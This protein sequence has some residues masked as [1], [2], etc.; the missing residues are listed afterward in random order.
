MPDRNGFVHRLPQSGIVTDSELAEAMQC[1]RETIGDWLLKYEIDHGWTG[2][3][4]IIDV[5]KFYAGLPSGLPADEPK[6][7]GKPKRKA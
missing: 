6:P 4:R 7:K 3:R 5:A 2:S 1:S